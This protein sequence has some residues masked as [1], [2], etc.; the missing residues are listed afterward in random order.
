MTLDQ[1]YL[2][3]YPWHKH[4]DGMNFFIFRE[5]SDVISYNMS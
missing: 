5:D 1:G 3:F 4:F 2:G